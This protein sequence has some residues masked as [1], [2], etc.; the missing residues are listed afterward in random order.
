LR[1]VESDSAAN[2]ASR[3]ASEYLTIKLSINLE[4]ALVKR[5]RPFPAP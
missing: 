1:R 4:W 5:C 3:A 2:T